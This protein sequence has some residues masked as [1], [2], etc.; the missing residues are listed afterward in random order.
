M[1]RCALLTLDVAV[2][3]SRSWPL[4]AQSMIRG[5]VRPLSQRSVQVNLPQ[6]WPALRLQV[7]SLL[8]EPQLCGL[9]KPSKYLITIMG[10][11]STYY[12]CDQRC[13]VRVSV[14]VCLVRVHASLARSMCSPPAHWPG[15]MLG[16]LQAW[17]YLNGVEARVLLRN[18]GRDSVT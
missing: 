11:M 15:F 16:E 3:R 4:A 5:L 7:N 12:Q 9:G 13:D 1:Y 10:S 18:A 2:L 8:V 6:V 17:D 14:L